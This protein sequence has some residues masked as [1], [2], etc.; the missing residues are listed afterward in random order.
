MF[1]YGIKYSNL[2]FFRV[3]IVFVKIIITIPNKMDLLVLECK[4]TSDR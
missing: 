3:E 2:Q 4:Y 1:L